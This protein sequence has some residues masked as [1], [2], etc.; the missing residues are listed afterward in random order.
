MV[1][2]LETAAEVATAVSLESQAGRVRNSRQDLVVGGWARGST[3]TVYGVS[4]RRLETVSRWEALSLTTLDTTGLSSPNCLTVSLTDPVLLAGTQPTVTVST[5]GLTT[6]S[7][8]LSSRR[9]R[10]T[11]L[12][13]SWWR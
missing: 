1:L 4:G 2:E 11:S 7:C 13:R 9:A 3:Q 10:D 6:T 5:P 12:Q 8:W